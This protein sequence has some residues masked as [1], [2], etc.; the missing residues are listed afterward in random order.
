MELQVFNIRQYAAFEAT[1]QSGSVSAAARAINLTQP[2]I[3][4]AIARLEAELE[5]SLFDRGPTGMH[6]TEPAELLAP[7][8]ASAL[9]LIG[10]PRVTG[11]QIRA[12]MAV[13]RAGSYS[14]A[15]GETGISS[16][17][18]HRAIADL[19]LALGQ[20]LF[21]RR[22]RSIA[23]THAGQRRARAFGL[24]LA[25]LRAGLDEVAAWQGKAA[26]RI[27]I[28]AMPLSRARWLPTVVAEF[29]RAHPGT[30]IAVIEG[31]YAELS[32]PLRDGEVDFMLGAIREA[33]PPEDLHQEA[34][35]IDRPQMVMR[36]GHPLLASP[37][38][39][40]ARLVEF[41]W[42]MPGPATPLR[43][44]WE[45]MLGQ[46]GIAP[47][48]VG[49]QC[50]SVL[51]IRELLLTGDALT[52][53]SPDQLRVELESGILAARPCPVEV[54]RAIGIISRKDWHPTRTQASMLDLLRRHATDT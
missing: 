13:A 33:E 46:C 23:L 8:V 48:R 19:S 44:Y 37:A 4:Q 25:E 6:P 22:G 30:E 42:I 52:L 28:G 1:V 50:G 14:E 51:T 24:A 38:T 7:R 27:A 5:C 20:H 16:A 3:T 40:P 12:F 54:R 26:G 34:C 32:G 53:L 35:F 49:V 15:A 9:A 18:L 11:T 2:A 43:H 39:D 29:T 10:S 31:S 41:P 21:D 17:S 45:D 47:P 36:A